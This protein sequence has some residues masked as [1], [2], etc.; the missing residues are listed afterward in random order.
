MAVKNEGKLTSKLQ[1]KAR[2]A[3]VAP[4]TPAQTIGAYLQKMAPEIEKALP[5]HM[6]IDRLTRISLTTIRTNPALLNC[7]MPSLLGAVM[8]AAQLGLEPGLLGHCYIIPYGKEA[9]FVIGYKGMIDLARRSG[10]IK[11]I[12]AHSVF[13]NDEFEYEY[14]L[15]PSLIHRPAMKER[16]EFIGAYAVA[17]FNDGGYQFE[18]MPKEEIEKRK[19]RSKAYKSG[20]WVTDYEEMAKKTVVRHMFKFLPISIEIMKQAA[21]DETVRKDITSEPK[22]VYG[23]AIEAEEVFAEDIPMDKPTQTEK[24]PEGKDDELDKVA[25]EFDEGLI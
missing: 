16:G 22:S 23:D 3:E 10:N 6:D 11:S 2:G 15:H 14:G 7:T 25:K 24:Q 9:T 5:K 17:H 8:Q 19:L 21:Q 1:D 4:P 12:Y 18:F 13:E 20:P